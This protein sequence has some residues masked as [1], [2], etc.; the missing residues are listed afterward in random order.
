MRAFS[1][2]L[3]LVVCVTGCGQRKESSET[4]M[5][6]SAQCSLVFPSDYTQFEKEF[7]GGSVSEA[8]VFLPGG[9]LIVHDEDMYVWVRGAAKW[10]KYGQVRRWHTITV[11]KS[12]SVVIDTK[13]VVPDEY[14]ERNG[15]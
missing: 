12:M 6:L 14:V 3:V 5:R 9:V 15:F 1:I 13:S 10:G 11:D 8:K 4:K 2:F 7:I